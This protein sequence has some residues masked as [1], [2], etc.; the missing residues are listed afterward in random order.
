MGPRLISRGNGDGANGLDDAAIASM[1]PRL[2]S[3]GNGA[4]LTA[5]TMNTGLQWGRG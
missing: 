2:I 3:R 1:G 5:L 4:T